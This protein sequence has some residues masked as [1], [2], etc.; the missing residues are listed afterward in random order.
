MAIQRPL[1]RLAL[2]AFAIGC[3]GCH[4][5]KPLGALPSAG[6]SCN[7]AAAWDTVVGYTSLGW[8]SMRLASEVPEFGSA[9][10]DTVL[11]VYLTDLSA[12][13][14]AQRTIDRYN[15]YGR[16]GREV[17]YVL[18]SYSY[19]Q[20]RGWAH[21]ILPYYPRGVASYEV[22][23]SKNR[24]RFTVINDQA[25]NHLE[26][27]IDRL[28]MPRDAF[29]IEHGEYAKVVTSF[30]PTRWLTNVAADKHFSDAASPR[31]W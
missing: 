22:L 14:H 7:F 26:L 4:N 20:L 21:C 10:V 11:K 29:I 8:P 23:E 31:W 17:R 30:W 28:G 18:G 12:R 3:A 24:N 9:Y 27:V 2:L 15:L 19:R 16:R 13:D 25:R 1:C 5:A 6:Q